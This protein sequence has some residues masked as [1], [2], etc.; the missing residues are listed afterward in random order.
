MSTCLDSIVNQSY[1]NWE[2]LVCNDHSTDD[3]WS[4]LLQYLEKDLRI[5][6]F[7][8]RGSGII[9][10]LQT[11]YA[12]SQ[13][14]FITRM[15][16]DDKMSS[17]KLEILYN[18]LKSNPDHKVATSKVQYFPAGQIKEGYLAYEHWLNSLC[19]HQS[20]WEEIYKECVIPSPNWM[21]EKNSFEECGGF[22]SDI[23]PEDYDL[24]WR[25][26]MN[27]IQVVS[28]PEVLHYWRDHPN[29]TSR[30]SEV[31]Q[32]QTY[33]KLKVKY[34][35]QIPELS[36]KKW[37]VWGAGRKGKSLIKILK[38][39]QKEEITWV[40][41]NSKKINQNIYNIVLQDCKIIPQIREKFIILVTVSSHTDRTDIEEFMNKNGLVKNQ[42]FFMLA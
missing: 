21:M 29:R 33:F 2:A 16:A 24:V 34:M 7:N 20:H 13:G 19:D 12:H 40:C 39:T 1:T 8:N 30:N 37:I 6:A 5:K 10:A 27:K 22:N 25:M 11:A 35:L 41:N 28:S 4:I 38:D 31:Y 15:D 18:L 26:F 9:D 3:S 14:S 42:D 36:Q 17:L 23:Y 32:T